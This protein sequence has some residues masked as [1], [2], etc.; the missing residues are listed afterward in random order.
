MTASK[1]QLQTLA[2]DFSGATPTATCLRLD[3]SLPWEQFVAVGNTIRQCADAS[4]WW[5]GDWLVAAKGR[6]ARRYD[7]A[8]QLWPERSREGLQSLA[9]V[10]RAVPP[11]VRR[12]DLEYSHHQVVAKL[13]E[14]EQIE[15]LTRAANE[16]MTRDQLRVAIADEATKHSSPATSA[17]ATTPA[18]TVLLTPAYA[19]VTQETEG[20]ATTTTEPASAEEPAP[21]VPTLLHLGHV[22]LVADA[23]RTVAKLTRYIDKEELAR[24]PVETW[25]ASERLALDVDLARSSTSSTTSSPST[26]ASPAPPDLPPEKSLCAH[27]LCPTH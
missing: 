10:C 17:G 27:K 19:G 16:G 13:T 26:S 1:Q 25:P 2:L 24:G 20:S 21:D 8:L 18:A 23:Q 6:Y 11:H 4:S 22:T 3:E 14:T 15:W 12:A 7:A 9:A 5:I